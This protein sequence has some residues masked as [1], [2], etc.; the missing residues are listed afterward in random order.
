MTKQEKIEE[1][2]KRVAKKH[3]VTT[4]QAKEFKLTQ[5][6]ISY[7]EKEGK[8]DSNNNHRDDLLDV[9]NIKCC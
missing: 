2:I 6:Y 9:D 1:Y 7:I 5:N 8:D 4:E 3:G